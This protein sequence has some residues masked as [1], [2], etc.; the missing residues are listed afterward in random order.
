[1]HAM[2]LA[3]TQIQNLAAR[4]DCGVLYHC[5][6]HAFVSNKL[7]RMINSLHHSAFEAACVICA[8]T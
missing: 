2:R 1:M 5:K 8:L 6:L 4:Y 3:R 7:M